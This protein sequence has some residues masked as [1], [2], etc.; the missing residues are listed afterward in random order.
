MVL[1]LNDIYPVQSLVEIFM[2]DEWQPGVVVDH[3]HPAVWVRLEKG[4]LL[5]VTNRRHIRKQ[6]HDER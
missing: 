6:F 4:A 1:R 2:M 5:F 3:A